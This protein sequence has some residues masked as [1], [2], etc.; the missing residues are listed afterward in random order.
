MDL[1]LSINI[2]QYNGVPFLVRNGPMQVARLLFIGVHDA[3]LVVSNSPLQVWNVFE[4]TQDVGRELHNIDRLVM[5]GAWV[6]LLVLR[7]IQGLRRDD[8]ALLVHPITKEVGKFDADVAQAALAACLAATGCVIR[9][10]V[11]AVRIAPWNDLEIRVKNVVVT[12][13]LH[14]MSH[15]LPFRKA[16]VHFEVGAS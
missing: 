2:L 5:L 12:V 11:Q 4:V 8:K 14:G 6:A 15:D 7:A 9:V 10:I 3:D 1:R 16:G 13:E